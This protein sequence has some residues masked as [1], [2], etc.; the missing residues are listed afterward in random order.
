MRSLL[1]SKR[2][3]LFCPG[4]GH[5]HIVKAVDQAAQSLDL[6]GEQLVIVSDIGCSGLFDTFF[7]CHAIHG[8]HGRAL[9]YATGL[10]MVRPEL[11][12]LVVM[13]DGGLG[14]GGAHVLASC[15]KNLDITL[16]VLNNF[17]YGMTGGQCSSTTPAS[18]QSASNFLNTLEAP[19]DICTVASA[20]GA[21]FK[22]KALANDS[23]LHTTIA[24][25]I[26]FPGFALLDIWGLCPGRHLKKNPMTSSQ[27]KAEMV[28]TENRSQMNNHGARQEYGAQYRLAANKAGRPQPLNEIEVVATPRIQKRSEIVIL[29]A[30][31][32]FINTVA[33][34][35]SLAAM[36]SGVFVTQKNDYPIT[37]LR[38]HSVAELVFDL[39]AVGYTGMTS[40]T[41]VL[42]VAQEGI[43]RRKSL[44][45]KLDKKT[46]ILSWPGLHIPPTKAEVNKISLG[47]M[48]VKKTQ[49]GLVLITKL[50][51]MKLVIEPATL[52]KA[53]TIRYS[54]KMCDQSIE[55]VNQLLSYTA[56]TSLD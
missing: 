9:T 51:E 1:N 46:T 52:K 7:N 25:A 13:G 49:R 16:L 35:V 3:L 43:E 45:E 27:L 18:A 33:E 47:G 2:P 17:N 14:I 6:K 4:C 48:K 32:Q 41:V 15:R 10:K 31:G 54:G 22:E 56:S 50:A 34:I 19:L 53:I 28:K 24:R 39:E 36:S 55:L 21:L 11:I 29:G 30:A 26:E 20:S 12:V 40:P 5:D 42:C 37:V 44:F 38:G 23:E 8:L